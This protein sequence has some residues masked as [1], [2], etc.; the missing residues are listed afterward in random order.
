MG[1]STCRELSDKECQWKA[2]WNFCVQR[3][4]VVKYQ[5]LGI[6]M[7][8]RAAAFLLYLCVLL[9]ASHGLLYESG[10]GTDGFSVLSTKV[11]L[12]LR[13]IAHRRAGIG[14]LCSLI[15]RVTSESTLNSLE[16]L[17][18]ILPNQCNHVFTLFLHHPSWLKQP[19]K[20]ERT[21]THCF[22]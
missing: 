4:Q 22:Q 16:E 11:C 9:G 5:L 12:C 19:R 10:C 2:R 13:Q 1:L 20:M 7:F 18:L 21:R 6:T 8:V 3:Q 14:S 17:Y 15:K